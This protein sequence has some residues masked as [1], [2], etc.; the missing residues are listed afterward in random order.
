MLSL[1]LILLSNKAKLAGY[2]S[3]PSRLLQLTFHAAKY[4]QKIEASSQSPAAASRPKKRGRKSLPGLK[5]AK[6]SL[7]YEAYYTKMTQ[8]SELSKF[9]VIDLVH[10]I[11][12]P[13][14][15]ALVC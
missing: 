8:E 10:F 9:K 13:V 6:E 3:M 2:V 12:I 11:R 15:P 1:L 5:P 7:T 14:K 4:A